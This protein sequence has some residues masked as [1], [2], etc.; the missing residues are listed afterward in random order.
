LGYVLQFPKQKFGLNF[1]LN[2]SLNTVGKENSNSFGPILSV[3]KGFLQGKIN[4]NAALSYINTNSVFE[5]NNLDALAFNIR[6][7]GNYSINKKHSLNSNIGITTS[8]I[9][10]S[11][12]RNNS[13]ATLGYG[14]RF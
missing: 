10:G 13:S 9:T 6:F 12:R 11:A 5:G 4:T 2:A 14:F 3:Q 8:E 7:N 1:G